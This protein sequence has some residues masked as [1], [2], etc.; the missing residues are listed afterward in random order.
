MQDIILLTSMS[1]VKIN[2]IPYVSLYHYIVQKNHT[3]VDNY[4]KA[5]DYLDSLNKLDRHFD[6]ILCTID[7]AK[8][9]F[10]NDKVY[11]VYIKELIILENQFDLISGY[12][13]ALCTHF[14]KY[15]KS[16]KNRNSVWGNV[17]F[18]NRI[19]YFSQKKIKHNK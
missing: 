11:K 8:E 17:D 7:K 3:R 9:E 1:K 16:I 2:N 12:V 10:N 19:N 15:D 14:E 6:E 13:K 5:K 4:K 18:K